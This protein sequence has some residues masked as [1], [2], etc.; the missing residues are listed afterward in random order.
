MEQNPDRQI[1]SLKTAGTET[2]YLDKMS[3]SPR[4]RPQPKQVLEDLHPEDEVLIHERYC[5]TSTY[6]R[7]YYLAS[8]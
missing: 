5:C 3:G 2:V 7:H 4:H 6:P 1:D 8:W